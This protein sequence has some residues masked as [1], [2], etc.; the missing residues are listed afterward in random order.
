MASGINAVVDQVVFEFVKYGMMGV[1]PL[2]LLSVLWCLCCRKAEEE[3]TVA[4]PTA[5]AKES[6]KDE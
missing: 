1:A 3:I 2:L 5:R 4:K 6:S